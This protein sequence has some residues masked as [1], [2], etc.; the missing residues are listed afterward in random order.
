MYQH[1]PGAHPVSPRALWWGM[2]DECLTV[3][4]DF[5]GMDMCA[6]LGIPGTCQFEELFQD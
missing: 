2:V 1:I 5:F 4:L 3:T 6:C